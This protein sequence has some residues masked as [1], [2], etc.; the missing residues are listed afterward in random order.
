MLQRWNENNAKKNIIE[1]KAKP[2]ATPEIHS[3]SL[4]TSIFIGKAVDVR[5]HCV[6]NG[7]TI[8]GFVIVLRIN[9]TRVLWLF[10]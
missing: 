10:E 2:T 8:V 4:R 1:K 9:D 5:W 3:S 6:F 7:I